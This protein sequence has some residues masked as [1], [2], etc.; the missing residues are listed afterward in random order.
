[1]L[2]LDLQPKDLTGDDADAFYRRI[3]EPLL[4]PAPTGFLRALLRRGKRSQDALERGRG[5]AFMAD[6]VL[7]NISALPPYHVRVLRVTRAGLPLLDGL[8]R[9][10]VEPVRDAGLRLLHGAHR[11]ATRPAGVQP[12]PASL[13]ILG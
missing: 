7:V 10:G 8:A 6:L 5:A 11:R 1:M 9:P 13:T 4:P 12:P 3:G 2:L